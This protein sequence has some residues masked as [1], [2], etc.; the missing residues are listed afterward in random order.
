MVFELI[1]ENVAYIIQT[2]KYCEEL[3]LVNDNNESFDKLF[4]KINSSI[5]VCLN[6]ND[7]NTFA[8]KSAKLEIFTFLL[9]N[10]FDSDFLCKNSL[11]LPKLSIELIIA[12]AVENQF[13][14]FIEVNF[15]FN[16]H[17]P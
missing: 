11:K 8:Q 10:Y 2:L 14:D 16:Q 6:C 7:S 5:Q 9:S 4:V 17:K 15:L 1:T 3:N 12:L 13:E